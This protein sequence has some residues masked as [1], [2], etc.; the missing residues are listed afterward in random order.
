MFSPVAKS[1]TI[2]LVLTIATHFHSPIKQVDVDDAFLHGFLDTPVYMLQPPGF[3]DPEEPAHVC[4]LTKS[5]YGLKHAPKA[6]YD[7]LRHVLLDQEFKSSSS[8][9]V[10]CKKL[11]W[12]LYLT[13]EG[14]STW[15]YN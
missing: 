9:D 8:A 5:F 11:L 2:R 7:T 3:V 13:K 12:F 4:I 6:W 14:Y 15:F 1:T 10:I